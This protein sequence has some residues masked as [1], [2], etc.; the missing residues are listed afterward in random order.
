[1]RK[2]GNKYHGRVEVLQNVSGYINAKYEEGVRRATGNADFKA[3]GR[4]WG[5]RKDGTP[6]V[7][8]KGEHYIQVK[9]EGKGA[10]S[11]FLD[12]KP[13]TDKTMIDEFL[14]HKKVTR[15]GGYVVRTFKLTSLT[16]LRMGGT[17]YFVKKG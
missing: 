16:E 15:D 11:Y 7:E 9:C 10:V 4:T 13:V 6:Y 14:K 1:M 3:Q 2:K 5:K 8:H 12:G 17:T